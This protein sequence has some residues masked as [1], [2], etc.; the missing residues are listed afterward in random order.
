MKEVAFFNYEDGST[1]NNLH[2]VV[3][4]LQDEV[5]DLKAALHSALDA[6]EMLTSRI[7]PPNSLNEEF[8]MEIRKKI[9]FKLDPQNG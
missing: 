6:I 9:G 8:R 1:G 5:T 2:E 3:G 7:A 4:E